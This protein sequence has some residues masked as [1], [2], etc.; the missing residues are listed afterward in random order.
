MKTD[1]AKYRDQLLE[2]ALTGSA[3][4]VLEAHLQSCVACTQEL[5]ALRA[6]R[7][8]MD[9][10]LPL[11]ARGAEPSAEFRAQVLS[12][13][14]AAG[15][16]RRL[17]PW[18]LWVLAGVTAA[19]AAALTTAWMVERRTSRMRAEDEIAAAEKLAEWRA[20]SDVLLETPGNE[21]LRTTP[22]LGESYL[23]VAS[24]KNQEE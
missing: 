11:L 16:Q 8:Q 9:T 14:E 22:K 10:M 5:A 4:G 19:V 6:R 23:K 1:C 18:R 2:A 12:A 24:K 21:I 17:R 15:K 7:E 20:P 13:A 3:E